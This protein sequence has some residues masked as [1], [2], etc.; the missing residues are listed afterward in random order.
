MLNE[1]QTRNYSRYQKLH[2]FLTA[3]TAIYSSYVPFNREVQ[4]FI[5]NFNLSK[6]LVPQNDVNC[7]SV[8]NS[9]RELKNK[10][11]LQVANICDMAVAYAKQYNDEKLA[12]AVNYSCYDVLNFKDTDVYELVL[13][14]INVLQPMFTDE[15]FMEYAITEE[16]LE[17]VMT[18]AINFADNLETS[19]WISTGSSIATQAV[20]E[21]LQQLDRNVQQFDRLINKFASTHPGFVAGYYMNTSTESPITYHTGIEGAII[22]A[23]GKLISNSLVSVA[24]EKDALTWAMGKFAIISVHGCECEITV[25][26]SGFTFKTKVVRSP[27][28]KAPEV[29]LAL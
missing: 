2:S 4:S 17:S 13:N 7:I 6:S 3:N 14:I 20:N 12:E 26:A 9:Q 23:D 1:V 8:T 25:D 11:A 18:D 16:M 24:R 28:S 21:I 22:S 15:L 10:I 5:T 29:N 19:G 27:N